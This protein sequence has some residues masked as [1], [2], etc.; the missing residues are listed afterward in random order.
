MTI[1]L[2]LFSPL[3]LLLSVSS[4]D[5]FTA[6]F[7]FSIETQHTIGYGG[8]ATNTECPEAIFVMCLQ[9]ITGV[10]IQCFVVGFVFAKLSRPQKR[11]QT[12]L[13]SNNAVISL[14]DGKLCLMFRIG[15]VRNR[16]HIIGAS[17]TAVVINRKCTSEGETIPFYQYE[18]PVKFDGSIN[19]LFLIWPATVVHVIDEES[20]FYNLNADTLMREK[21]EIVVILEGTV[22]ST[23]Q[24][25]QARSSY[26]PSEILWG[27]R[28]DQLV[29]YK[30]DTGEHRVDYSRFNGTYEVETPS[31][32]AR[33]LN[34]IQGKLTNYTPRSNIHFKLPH[35]SI[36]S[37][38]PV[39]SHI[40]HNTTSPL[41]PYLMSNNNT[42]Q[43][44]H[45]QQQQQ[46]ML[47][48]GNICVDYTPTLASA[49]SI[50]LASQVN[51]NHSISATGI[52]IGNNRANSHATLNSMP[53]VFS[54][55]YP[56]TNVI[57]SLTSYHSN[58]TSSD[59]HSTTTTDSDSAAT[60]GPSFQGAL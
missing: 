22:E 2:L 60:S 18:I 3:F 42:Q 44:Q 37:P 49:Q 9:S 5:S 31:C 16:S 45:Q 43:H 58:C 57:D 14:R 1:F 56:G 33:E 25:I 48:H 55:V 11:S 41:V 47:H 54:P 35:S 13:F 28:F 38:S 26:L 46:Q 39:S 8:R 17:V 12:L 59:H 7:L 29:T 23:G 19:S 4:L 36:Q 21:F 10:V 32:S 27:R 30:K 53:V 40:S 51:Y 15:D 24:S 52:M 20:P 50:P 6:A 34:E